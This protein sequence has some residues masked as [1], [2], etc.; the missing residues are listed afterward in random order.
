MSDAGLQGEIDPEGMLA[1]AHQEPPHAPLHEQPHEPHQ[2]LQEHLHSAIAQQ[3][4]GEELEERWEKHRP[5]A[6][7]AHESCTF[8]GCHMV[9]EEAR[10][11][12][13]S[14]AC[15]GG[16]LMCAVCVNRVSIFNSLASTPFGVLCHCPINARQAVPW[17]SL[18]AFQHETKAM[19]IARDALALA[20]RQAIETDVVEA[21]KQ[22]QRVLEQA[23]QQP[24]APIIEQQI[25]MELARVTTEVC[26]QCSAPYFAP[27]DL[28]TDCVTLHCSC[29]AFI[30]APCGHTTTVDAVPD[31]GWRNTTGH[32]H[33]C[34]ICKLCR[35]VC[36]RNSY[37]HT[38]LQFKM[39]RAR[40]RLD[41]ASRLWASLV[42]SRL[43]GHEGMLI[44]KGVV[45]ALMAEDRVTA[46]SRVTGAEWVSVEHFEQQYNAAAVAAV[47]LE[48]AAFAEAVASEHACGDA[49]DNAAR[50]EWSV[51][52]SAVE[53]LNGTD[54]VTIMGHGDE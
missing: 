13:I 26:G 3:H 6:A 46:R 36:R 54:L 1:R 50:I 17:S 37:Y 8:C 34:Q 5:R 31:L 23:T 12:R 44:A 43:L 41:C 21:H 33:S 15:P 42:S 48:P 10:Q 28:S 11:M 2:H 52:V 45:D 49:K 25:R 35:S 20:Q 14:W 39:A 30:C 53:V 4:Q 40:A 27:E 18:Q 29:G 19:D 9:E 47:A 7:R 22:A 32:E 16:C 24:L 51:P 38:P